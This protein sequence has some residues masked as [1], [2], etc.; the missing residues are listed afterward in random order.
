ML[1]KISIVFISI[2]ILLIGIVNAYAYN[3]Y[4]F[5]QNFYYGNVVAYKWGGTWEPYQSAFET[6]LSDWNGAQSDF[7]WGYSD[8]TPS[9]CSD[10]R[11]GG[12]YYLENANEAGRCQMAYT[13]SSYVR[14]WCE[15]NQ[16]VCE[17]KTDTYRR[18]VANHEVGHAMS[19]AHNSGN[20]IMNPN[21]DK[22]FIFVPQSLDISA[23]CQVY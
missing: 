18:S 6:A 19:L 10:N 17:S 9:G 21:R 16:F 14:A 12:V 20:V 13:T 7:Q 4:S 3:V 15:I 1:K 11:M 2:L 23:V 22:N 5:K 8:S